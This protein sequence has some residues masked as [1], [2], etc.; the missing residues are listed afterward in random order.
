MRGNV[1]PLGLSTLLTEIVRQHRSGVL[2]LSRGGE[3][4]SIRFRQGAIV[5]VEVHSHATHPA[6]PAHARHG[7]HPQ[8]RQAPAVAGRP[9]GLVR[10][11]LLKGLAWTEGS[12]VFSEEPSG[13][14]QSGD[15]GLELVTREVLLDLARRLPS[16]HLGAALGDTGRMV[17]TTADAAIRRQG[18]HLTPAED[19]VLR[20]L[21]DPIEAGA[22]IRKN[23]LP[24]EEVQR[25]LLGL[26]QAGLAEYAASEGET[27]APPPRAAATPK[28]E[29]ATSRPEPAAAT[30]QAADLPQRSPGAGPGPAGEAKL[31]D[32]PPAVVAPS[33]TDWSAELVAAESAWM[34]H[35]RMT[36]V[37]RLLESGQH[38]DALHVLEEA[39]P[40]LRE[41]EPRT[42]PV[43][44][45]IRNPNAEK[46]LEELLQEVLREQ[47]QNADAAFALAML[48]KSQGLK[49]RAA[50]LF[51]R[52]LEVRPG[53]ERSVAELAR[54]RPGLFQ[55]LLGRT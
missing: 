16:A 5:N 53:H 28:E 33:E 46:R 2:H 21:G 18:L 42:R 3:S 15:P 9:V 54:P 30:S 34:A 49:T 10:E 4:L 43:R 45:P 20:D 39:L 40:K 14:S 55:R 48:Y 44:T 50:A 11:K 47:P 31:A 24:R 1:S 6:G 25:G 27:S 19:A 32:P 17:R 26:L 51:Q 38:A 37:E 7:S 23:A 36:K 8:G 29:Q 12:Y 35:E 52:V 41:R 22:L 13:G